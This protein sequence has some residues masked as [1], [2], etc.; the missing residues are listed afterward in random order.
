MLRQLAGVVS[1]GVGALSANHAYCENDDKGSAFK[2]GM[3]NPEELERAAKAVREIDRSPNAKQ[4]RRPWLELRT[5]KRCCL[6]TTALPAYH[7]AFMFMTAESC[8]SQEPGV[9]GC[10]CNQDRPD[11]VRK[12]VHQPR[13]SPSYSILTG[14][15]AFR[16]S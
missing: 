10:Q 15:L 2:N 14:Y 6:T 7:D 8:V 4:V 3:I 13:A 1:V 11:T 9:P 12:S 16:V 5:Q